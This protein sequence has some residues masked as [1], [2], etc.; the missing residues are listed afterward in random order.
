MNEKIHYDDFI[1]QIALESGYDYDT[2]KDYV[3]VMFETIIIQNTKG[4]SVKLRN[5]G[6]F[7]PRWY[8]AKR[9][10]NPQTQQP[11]IIL[12][13]YHVHFASSKALQN[14]LNDKASKPFLPKLILVALAVLLAL[15]YFY[16]ST[17]KPVTTK[18][19]NTVQETQTVKPVLEKPVE[20]QKVEEVMQESIEEEEKQ[21]VIQE[22]TQTKNA[23]LYSG[24][25]T[26]NTNDSLSVIGL[27][28]YG[29]KGYWP[30]LYS[31]NNSK[32]SNPDLI[33]TGDSLVI[34]DKTASKSLYI[35]YMD[36]YN[37]YKQRDLVGK[38]FWILCEGSHF[39]GKDFQI[40]LKKK[41]TPEE[42]AIIQRCSSK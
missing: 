24:S 20:A 13:H 39:M 6:S 23:P 38:S 12:P 27:R 1:E 16:T 26:I 35:S 18:I 8:K 19:V 31:A 4:K 10:I 15:A 36:V 34:P 28:V 14:A 25:Y 32:V 11:L 41:L 22:P 3:S 29:N 2:V 17:N 33:F 21:Q 40:Y 37:A 7:Q 42:Y 5:F 9:G 30:L